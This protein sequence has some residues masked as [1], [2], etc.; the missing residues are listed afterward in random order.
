[1]YVSVELCCMQTGLNFGRISLE[2]RCRWGTNRQAHNGICYVTRKAMSC[3][4]IVPILEYDL[5]LETDSPPYFW[6]AVYINVAW[7][8]NEERK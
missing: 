3:S 4:N 7:S 1:M 6:W 5:T 8:W 2:T